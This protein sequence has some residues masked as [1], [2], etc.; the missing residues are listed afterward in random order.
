MWIRREDYIRENRQTTGK[1]YM[2]KQKIPTQM[3][4][5]Y[6]YYC[7]VLC[8]Q[9]K[10]G[11]YGKKTFNGKKCCECGY[12][13]KTQGTEYRSEQ[14]FAYD[15]IRSY[16]PTY[17]VKMEHELHDLH[18][19]DGVKAKFCQPDITVCFGVK[20]GTKHDKK[21]IAI[22]LNGEV[23]DRSTQKMKDEDQRIV[24]EGN[25]WQVVDFWYFKMPNLFDSNRTEKKDFDAALECL[26]V[27]KPYLNNGKV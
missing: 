7:P 19:V 22:R 20:C 4:T 27:I 26:K 8:Q 17:T 5:T 21:K 18:D 15:L 12:E 23:H 16:Y 14:V 10:N 1:T 2:K 13:K 11:S 9:K 3:K 25:G 24:L 6:D